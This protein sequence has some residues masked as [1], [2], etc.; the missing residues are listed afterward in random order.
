MG[1]GEVSELQKFEV[2]LKK[3]GVT[4]NI[5]QAVCC[6]KQHRVFVL[7]VGNILK[8]FQAEEAPWKQF[9][10][11]VQG[12]SRKEW[13]QS[14]QRNKDLRSA[15][16]VTDSSILVVLSCKIIHNVKLHE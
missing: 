3:S 16:F 6:Y 5:Y 13:R 11:D 7:D 8:Q 2:G 4:N 12:R 1:H 15:C 10:G 14:I 9:S